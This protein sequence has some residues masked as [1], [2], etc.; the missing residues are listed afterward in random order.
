MNAENE[1]K[2]RRD[3]K[4]FCPSSKKETILVRY[5]FLQTKTVWVSHVFNERLC[6]QLFG[7]KHC[8]F[9]Q[10]TCVTRLEVKLAICE[11]SGWMTASTDWSVPN[12]ISCYKDPVRVRRWAICKA[13]QMAVLRAENLL[14]KSVA[15]QF[16][17][18]H[19]TIR[20]KSVSAL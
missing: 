14:I 16:L 3:A 6:N 17:N 9:Y 20:K 15:S 18:F 13:D 1:W 8:L 5:A 10:N 19:K 12:K 4:R 2:C 11:K 7:I